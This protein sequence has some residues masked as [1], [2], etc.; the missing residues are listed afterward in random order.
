MDWPH[1]PD[2]EQGSEGMR[3]YGQAILAKKIDDAEDFPLATEEFVAEHGEE[4][5][6]IN[7]KRVV[8]VAEL[9]ENVEEEEF[10]D[11]PAFH[12][13]I[14]SAMREHGFWDYDSETENPDRQ[15]A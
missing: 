3:K 13:A 8:S 12:V 14:G 4:P 15:R 6:R 5:V 9:F 11:F 10:G 7:H 1:D 2:G